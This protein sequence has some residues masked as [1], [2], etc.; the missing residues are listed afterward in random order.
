MRNQWPEAGNRLKLLMFDFNW[1]MDPPPNESP[2][3]S[4]PHEW[5]FVDP[6][7]Y[8]DWHLKIGNNAIFLQAY[9]HGGYAFYPTKLG[10]TAPGPGRDM[11]PRVFE[12]AKKA[13]MPFYSYF[14]P[15]WDGVVNMWRQEWLF[16]KTRTCIWDYWLAPESPWTDLFCARIEEFLHDY[17]ADV[18][19]IDWFNYNNGKGVVPA[20]FVEKPWKEIIG[21]PMPEKAEDITPEE[22]LK[23]R[24]EIMARQFYRIRDAARKASPNT[25]L[26]FT[27]PYKEPAEP[28]WVDHPMMNESDGVIA[29]YSKPETMEW[30]ISV[31]KPHQCVIA[32]PMG[33]KHMEEQTIR[34]LYA[35][36]CG[37]CGYLWGS[38][39]LFAP[40]PFF[41]K[42]LKI[43]SQVFKEM[44]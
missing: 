8:F 20:P 30:L 36:G 43:V 40:H 37:M 5:A 14:C 17:P 31:L 27:P 21:R 28:L 1:V 3:V 18:L 22:S 42:Q 16:P 25:K 24:R 10:P 15:S 7:E 4:G 32:T 39:P 38:A 6:K 13:G 9:A 26:L 2:R 35:R 11:L 12:L 23:Y 34:D 19:L 33:P 44:S 41:E 29:E